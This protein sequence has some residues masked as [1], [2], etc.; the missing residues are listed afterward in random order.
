MKYLCDE[1]GAKLVTE[2]RCPPLVEIFGANQIPF[3]QNW[4]CADCGKVATCMQY[5]DTKQGEKFEPFE[6]QKSPECSNCKFGIKGNAGLECH[7]HAPTT[8]PHPNGMGLF[9]AV[10]ETDWCGDWDVRFP[11]SGMVKVEMQF[12]PPKSA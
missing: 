10:K 12:M 9:P 6:K 11:D 7:R 8:H 1:C 5:P 2:K 4:G 3:K